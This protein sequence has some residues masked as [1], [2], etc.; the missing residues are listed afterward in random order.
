MLGWPSNGVSWAFIEALI[1]GS[2]YTT[3]IGM[4]S[5]VVYLGMSILGINT[6]LINAHLLH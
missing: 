4:W 3:I 2:H 6:G 1:H 5:T